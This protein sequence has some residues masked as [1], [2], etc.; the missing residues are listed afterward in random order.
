MEAEAQEKTGRSVDRQGSEQAPIL[1]KD[2]DLFRTVEG[3]DIDVAVWRDGEA[4]GERAPIR[5]WR[6]YRE[7][8]RYITV[9][10]R[11]RVGLRKKYC[12]TGTE[13]CGDLHALGQPAHD[14]SPLLKINFRVG[15]RIE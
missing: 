6:Q 8:L 3:G 9:E 15:I 10:C 4:L 7:K 14:V 1:V 2:E 11:R 5:Q 13:Q 12:Q